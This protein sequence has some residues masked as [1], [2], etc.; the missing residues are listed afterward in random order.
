MDASDYVRCDHNNGSLI[1]QSQYL[2]PSPV[3][4]GKPCVEGSF[5]AYPLKDSCQWALGAR[6]SSSS[7]SLATTRLLVMTRHSSV[8]SSTGPRRKFFAFLTRV[9]RTVWMCSAVIGLPARYFHKPMGRGRAVAIARRRGYKLSRDSCQ[10]LVSL[11]SRQLLR[12][13]D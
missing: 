5:R 11:R 12:S 8:Y 7:V 10:R 3:G 9:A 4:R 2:Q 13:G 6:T 1:R